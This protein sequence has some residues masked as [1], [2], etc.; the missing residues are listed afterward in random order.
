MYEEKNLNLILLVSW[1]ALI[2]LL[3]H[4]TASSLPAEFSQQTHT[5]GHAPST[6]SLIAFLNWD[7]L[8]HASAYAVMAFLAWRFFNLKGYRPSQLF[9]ISFIFC[10][11]YGI[12]DEWHQSFIAGRESDILDWLA[13]T[14]GAL[15]ILSFI[16]MRDL[17]P[18]FVEIT[19]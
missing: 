13:D 3:S 4:L 5:N 11:L 19:T 7:K 2:F 1:C 6:S 18:D 15:I 17:Q 10:S 16:Y 12:S 9:T 8:H 14:T